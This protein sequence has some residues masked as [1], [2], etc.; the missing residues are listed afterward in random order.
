MS[1]KIDAKVWATMSE[2][3]KAAVTEAMAK[4]TSKLT[5]KVGKS[6]GVSLYGLGRY[7]VTL[8]RQQWERL[9]GEVPAIQAFIT[10]HS[11]ELKVKE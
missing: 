4:P 6:G 3:Q 2:E 7:P 5:C 8:Y 1:N 11:A 9:I 10:A